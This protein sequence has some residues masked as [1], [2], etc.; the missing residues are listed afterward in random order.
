[1]SKST[2]KT[3]FPNYWFWHNILCLDF[4]IFRINICRYFAF[5]HLKQFS[6]FKID[7]VK[8][9]W[10]YIFI[11]YFL[12]KQ[13][14]LQQI[15]QWL[16]SPPIQEWSPLRQ[17]RCRSHSQPD[18]NVCLTVINNCEDLDIIT[19]TVE[20]EVVL[21]EYYRVEMFEMLYHQN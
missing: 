12:Q 11:Y 18:K 8:M 2:H 1:M 3:D 19:Q 21:I 5:W 20:L 13:V 4:N 7:L 14:Q 15:H 10:K 9:K 6:N 16:Q 17:S